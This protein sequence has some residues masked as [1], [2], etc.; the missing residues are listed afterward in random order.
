[1]RK[2]KHMLLVAGCLFLSACTEDALY[3]DYGEGT[4][5]LVISGL[6]VETVVGDI[7][8][9]ASMMEEEDIPGV[10]EF[11][12]VLVNTQEASSEILEVGTNEIEAG[13]Y[14]ITASA[15][16]KDGMSYTPFFSDEKDFEIVKGET[17]SITL[18]PSLQ[19]AVLHPKMDEALISQYE[20][21]ELSIR[22]DNDPEIELIDNKDF[23]LAVDADEGTYY[24]TLSGRNKLGK[25]V[26]HTWEYPAN[27]FVAKTRYTVNC[28]PDLPTFTMS[29]QVET[30][31]WSKFIY[32]TPMTA[33][34]IS[35]KP[36]G[37]TDDDIL[38]NVKYEVSADGQVWIQANEKNGRLVAEGLNPS[39]SYSVRAN[40]LDIYSTNAVSVTTESGAGVPNGDFEE[41]E[42]TINKTIDQGGKW[43]QAIDFIWTSTRYQT[44]LSMVISEPSNWASINQKTCNFNASKL[45]SWYMVPSTYNTSLS[46]LS[47]QPEAKVGVVGQDAY[48]STAGIYKK[49]SFNGNNAMV[50]RNVAWD[51]NGADIAEDV[52][53]GNTDYS[54]YYCSNVPSISNRSAGKLFLG[55]YSY[56]NGSEE[57]N[58]GIAFTTRPISLKGYYKYAN[59]SQDASEKGEVIVQ[60]MSG[61]TVIASGELELG[62]AADYSEFKVSLTYTN[63]NIKATELR[64]MFS[65][66]NHESESDIKTTNYCN[67]D[68]C[69]SRGAMLTIDNLT[70]SY[71]YPNN[72]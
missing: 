29:E 34:N 18:R 3:Q 25:D 33:A 24:L 27:Q 19:N 58:E 10:E 32:I 16:E 48:D 44:T 67:K 35:Y 65:S 5:T 23:Y 49:S 2:V 38:A 4:G 57:Y 66:S 62:A 54:N 52:K 28:D 37:L 1:M 6:E 71:E 30:D 51:L 41:L 56:N 46:W 59:D 40:F 26:S 36:E 31:A 72:E 7:Q 21:Y 45:N 8:T 11:T 53:T 55:S 9:K 12:I 63:E 15:G 47:H 17:K 20:T 14:N 13:S 42:E 39:T 69:C 60:L 43:T 70:F 68:E 22:K 61:E 64:I 50:V